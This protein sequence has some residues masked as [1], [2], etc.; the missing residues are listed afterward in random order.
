MLK[1]VSYSIFDLLNIQ[2]SFPISLTTNF[3]DFELGYTINLPK[4]ITYEKEL[5]T[6]GFFSFSLGYMFDFKRK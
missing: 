3:W 1:D 2:I 5:N 6:T 4:A